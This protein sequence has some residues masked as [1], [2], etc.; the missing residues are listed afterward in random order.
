MTTAI[1]V[2]SH[3]SLNPYLEIRD[4][5]VNSISLANPERNVV[6]L[7]KT[8]P[9]SRPFFILSVEAWACLCMSVHYHVSEI[10]ETQYESF[11]PSSFIIQEYCEALSNHKLTLLTSPSTPVHTDEE[12]F[13]SPGG[14]IVSSFQPAIPLPNSIRTSCIVNVSC[15]RLCISRIMF[16]HDSRCQS[17]HQEELGS[18][19]TSS[20]M[21]G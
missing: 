14:A 8:I 15:T 6:A 3:Y 5:A 17:L 10:K 7:H 21:N 13:I 9:I 4:T 18:Y 2:Q 11:L 20:G 19:N 1:E 12:G 16:T